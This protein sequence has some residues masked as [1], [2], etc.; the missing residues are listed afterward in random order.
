MRAGILGSLMQSLLRATY[1]WQVSV[2]S[3]KSYQWQVSVGSPKS[4]QWQIYED[5]GDTVF[6]D[7]G[8]TVFEDTG[9]TE[10]DK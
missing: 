10:W 5:T 8:D 1:Q 2:G 6:E 9:D 4:Y 7:T 3:P